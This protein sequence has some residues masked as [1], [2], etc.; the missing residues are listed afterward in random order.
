[1]SP[2]VAAAAATAQKSPSVTFPDSVVE[3]TPSPEVQ[4]YRSGSQRRATAHPL[5]AASNG[6]DASAGP[7]HLPDL[8]SPT[9]DPSTMDDEIRRV[10]T[11]ERRS[12]HGGV[13]LGAAITPRDEAS[14]PLLLRHRLV[15][16]NDLRRRGGTKDKKKANRL[17]EFYTSQNSHIENLLKPMAK[18][19][20]DDEDEKEGAA[21]KVKIAIYASIIANFA[22]AGLQL[23]AAVSSLSL[24]LF[25]T[26]ADSV[27]D[28]FA[29]LV[30]NWLHRKS[31]SV[32]ET[33]W[34]IG[35]ARFETIGNIVY[36]F[37]MGSVSAILI[38]QSLVDIAGHSGNDKN[39]LHIPSLIAVGGAFVTKFILFLYCYGI[40]KHSSQVQV[41]FEDHRNDLF[42]NGFGIFTSAA[43]A[44][45]AWWLDPTG[46][47]L[48]SCAII[49]SWTRTAYLQFRELA[50]AGAPPEFLSLIVYNAMLHHEHIKQIDSCKAYH[51]G[52]KYI[53][54]VDLVMDPQTPLWLS[55]D[56][57]QDLQ[58]RI[59]DL[60]MVERAFIH[61]DHETDH[62]PEHRKNV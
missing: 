49:F 11:G 54:E 46:A 43:G 52:P 19:A 40:R 50:G 59:E 23:Y 60:P 17:N 61:V 22:L 20:S 25:A 53:V 41:L 36:A 21:L 47:I 31:K 26:A 42:I 5:Q 51:S 18:H 48:I 28:P 12:S 15:A 62:R 1:M 55:H 13:S 24:S 35:G 30:L 2:F 6:T 14:D 27:F 8:S 7:S 38:V 32:D 34:P 10:E 3:R 37:L 33:K 29:N 39:E 4:I 16:D 57:S 44:K 56:V 58:D 45:I 9:V